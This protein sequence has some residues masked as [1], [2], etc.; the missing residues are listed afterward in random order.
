MAVI[1]YHMK[2]NENIAVLVKG[3]RAARPD[4]TL[5]VHSSMCRCDAFAALGVTRSLLKPWTPEDLME[6]L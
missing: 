6:L 1:D 3:T 2:E 5:V 4:V